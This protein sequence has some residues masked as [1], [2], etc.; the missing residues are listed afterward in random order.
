MHTTDFEF[1]SSTSQ[2]AIQGYG[3]IFHKG[4]LFFVVPIRTVI[5]NARLAGTYGYTT[6]IAIAFCSILLMNFRPRI[7][8]LVQVKN[9]SVHDVALVDC[10][11]IN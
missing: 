10:T 3:Y 11:F 4:E 5:T 1:Y 9:F 2:G 6:S 8:R 7:I